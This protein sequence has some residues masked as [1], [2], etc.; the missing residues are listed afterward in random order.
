MLLGESV[1][2]EDISIPK[3]RELVQFLRAEVLPFVSFSNATRRADGWELVQVEVKPEVPN[4]PVND[5]R[6]LES[7]VIE[8]DPAD[9]SEPSAIALRS[10]FPS[11]PHTYLIAKG[12]PLRLCLFNEPYSEQRLR[13]TASAYLHRLHIWLSKTATGTLHQPDQPVKPFLLG[14]PA[15]IVLPSQFFETD[16]SFESQPPLLDVITRNV[17]SSSTYIARRPG[18]GIRNE[19]DLKCIALVVETIPQTQGGLTHNP[20]NLFQLQEFLIKTMETDILQTFQDS[21]RGWIIGQGGDPE[22]FVLV[23]LRVPVRRSDDG[24]LE[25]VKVRAFLVDS[26]AQKLGKSLGYLVHVRK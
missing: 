7:I 15:K 11:V 14:S 4:R 2:P 13:W 26:S 19:S 16:Y 20:K 8:F 18:E 17:P 9:Q 1:E 22:A 23:V 10:D 5:I 21:L 6:F 3:A 24:P 12:E 25:M